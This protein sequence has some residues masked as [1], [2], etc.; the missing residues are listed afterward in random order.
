MVRRHGR[1]AVAQ[2][3][4][5]PAILGARVPR[6]HQAI[7]LGPLDRDQNALANQRALVRIGRQLDPDAEIG[8][9]GGRLGGGERLDRQP[10]RAIRIE[11]VVGDPRQI[12]QLMLMKDEAVSTRKLM[13]WQT[14]D[15]ASVVPDDLGQVTKNT[16]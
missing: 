10:H 11:C 2:I 6:G 9:D 12:L 3:V 7:L 16:L 14:L 8:I 4:H 5:R 13:V 15:H 1:S